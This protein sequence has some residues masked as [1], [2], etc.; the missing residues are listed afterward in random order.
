MKKGI[1]SLLMF[2]MII[3]A[4]NINLNAQSVTGVANAEVI[5][6]LSAAE[7]SALNFG[8][9]S[10]ELLGG[11]VVVSPSG[12]RSATGSVALM[13]GTVNQGL[14]Q[15]SGMP[16]YKVAIVLPVTATVTNATTSKTMTITD[17]TSSPVAGTGSPS[18][19]VTIPASGGVSLNVGGTLNVGNF[20][21]NPVGPYTGTYVI[22]FSY[23]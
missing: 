2:G 16:T 12:N 21:A 22:T 15:I 23:N 19:D 10:P 3:T 11:T 14:F 7:S 4:S 6:T 17:F 5:S 9:F 13:G 20:T 18:G 8:K 1:I